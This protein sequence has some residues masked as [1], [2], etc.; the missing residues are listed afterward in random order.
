STSGGRRSMEAQRKLLVELDRRPKLQ[1]EPGPEYPETNRT[2]SPPL[3]VHILAPQLLRVALS[4]L[5]RTR[6]GVCLVD[7]PADVVVVAGN[8]WAERM[9]AGQPD[10][11][12]RWQPGLVL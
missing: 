7:P 1:G 2:A 6:A 9:H 5:L 8:D 11:D 3:S 12:P 4:C 10:P